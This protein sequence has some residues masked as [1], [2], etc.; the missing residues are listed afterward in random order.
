MVVANQALIRPEILDTLLCQ[1]TKGWTIEL[2]KML[3]VIEDS[4]N[5]KLIEASETMPDKVAPKAYTNKMQGYKLWKE[6][7]ISGVRVKPGITAGLVTLCLANASVSASMKS[8]KYTVYCH[9][10]QD[11]AEVL[12]AKCNCKAGQGGCCKHIAAL[13]YALLD[14]SNLGLL[15]VPED[16]TCTQVLQKWSIS[17]KKL[18]GNVAVK[19]SDL[20]F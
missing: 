9:I 8:V 10:N 7:Y 20:E 3:R 2:S 6:G 13:L 12:Y 11:T 14:F 18:T 19:F 5:K 15:Y 4:P 1:D 16:V 17:S